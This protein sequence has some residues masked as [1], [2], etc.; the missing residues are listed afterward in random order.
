VGLFV[1]TSGWAYPEWRGAFYPPRLP[2]RRFLEHYAGALTACEVNA[3]FYRI[4]SPGAM[5]GWAGAVPAGFRFT[6]KGH[7]RLS[8]RKRIAPSEPER[9]FVAE[10]LDSLAPLAVR[11]GCLMIQFPPFVERDDAGLAQLLELLPDDL[12][13]ACEF[14]HGSWDAREVAERLAEQGGTVCLREEHGEAPRGLPPG[15]LAYLR[16]KGMRYEA[17]ERGA[18]RELLER[19]ARDRDVYAFARHKE[20]APDDPHTGLGLARWLAGG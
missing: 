11:L 8:Y 14:Q 3:T 16:L 13:F 1:G 17:R 4:Q 20:V 2:Q 5:A 9:A 19:E 18:L 7:R 10:F 15:P 12:R 6:V